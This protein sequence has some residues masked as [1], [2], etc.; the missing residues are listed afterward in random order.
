MS[1][2]SEKGNRFIIDTAEQKLYIDALADNL[3][4]L[5]DLAGISQQELADICGISRQTLSAIELRKRDMSWTHYMCMMF[6]FI[7]NTNTREEIQKCGAFPEEMLIRMN[8]G[9]IPDKNLDF[10][11]EQMNRLLQGLDER[12]M[13]TIKT[14]LL[15]E[16]ARCNNMTGDAVVKSFDGIDFIGRIEISDEDIDTDKAFRK[17]KRH[18]R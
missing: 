7:S 11:N 13:H 6:F 17:V 10:H 12:A 8:G 18:G 9:I 16:Y 15:V 2:S 14:M 1:R 3:T 4:S 5:R